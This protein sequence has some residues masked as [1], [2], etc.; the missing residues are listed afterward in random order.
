[1]Q[2]VTLFEALSGLRLSQ[3]SFSFFL[4]VSVCTI[5]NDYPEEYSE[6][7]GCLAVTFADLCSTYLCWWAIGILSYPATAITVCLYERQRLLFPL[8][9]L[10]YPSSLFLPITSLFFISLSFS[11]LP[12]HFLFTGCVQIYLT[13]S[14]YGAFFDW[15]N[16]H[17]HHPGR[18]E[19]H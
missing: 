17:K 16:R 11:Y 13:L 14:T 1:M 6:V 9:L 5:L 3:L 19:D 2:W 4:G 8:V 18:A 15:V 7:L 10:Q 12:S